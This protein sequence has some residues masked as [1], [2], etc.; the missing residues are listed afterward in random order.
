MQIANVLETVKTWRR[1]FDKVK[2][3][4]YEMIRLLDEE[5]TFYAP[6]AKDVY[7]AGEFNN[8]NTRSIPMKKNKDGFWKVTIKLSLRP[9]TYKFF[10]DGSWA[11]TQRGAEMAPNVMGVHE[12]ITGIE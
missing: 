10:V 6:D 5:F 3:T 4:I 7:L 12:Y 11:Q 1:P 8:W 9:H 2:S